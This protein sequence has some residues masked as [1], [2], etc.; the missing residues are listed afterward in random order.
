MQLFCLSKY[1]R[2]KE[3]ICKFEGVC[4]YDERYSVIVTYYQKLLRVICKPLCDPFWPLNLEEFIALHSIIVRVI[5][6][7]KILAI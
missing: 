5:I 3:I 4:C 1:L 6:K 2:Y 7:E